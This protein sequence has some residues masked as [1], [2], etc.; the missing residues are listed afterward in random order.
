MKCPEIENINIRYSTKIPDIGIR[1]LFSCTRLTSL[2][3]FG[4]IFTFKELILIFVFLKK[5]DVKL[6]YLLQ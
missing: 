3:L 6:F 2:N 1:Y 4:I 5:K